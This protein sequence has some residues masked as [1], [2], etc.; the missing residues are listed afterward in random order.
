LGIRLELPMLEI[1]EASFVVL[2]VA[3]IVA[4]AL[5]AFRS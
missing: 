5:D 4:H 2:G 3:I 1:I